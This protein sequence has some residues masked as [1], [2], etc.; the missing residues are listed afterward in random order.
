[1]QRVLVRPQ[2]HNDTCLNPARKRP[3]QIALINLGLLSD[4]RLRSPA[5][6]KVVR[7][8]LFLATRS[9]AHDLRHVF[10]PKSLPRNSCKNGS[11]QGL[12]NVHSLHP[13]VSSTT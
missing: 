10:R 13:K 12:V 11:K 5:V 6:T 2:S 3:A 1:M 7:R 4:L 9:W 8:D